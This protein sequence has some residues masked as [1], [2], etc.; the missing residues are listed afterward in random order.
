M[1]DIY[2]GY[3]WRARNQ[4]LS[5]DFICAVYLIRLN[6]ENYHEISIFSKK[7]TFIRTRYRQNQHLWWHFGDI[8]SPENCGVFQL[9]KEVTFR[10]ILALFCSSMWSYLSHTNTWNLT[11]LLIE[12]FVPFKDNLTR[13]GIYR[14]VQVHFSGLLPRV[15]GRR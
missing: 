5:T 13:I 3:L 6:I 14:E 8:M 4:I 7:L 2:H 12:W 1:C 15:L 9:L 10:G 11:T